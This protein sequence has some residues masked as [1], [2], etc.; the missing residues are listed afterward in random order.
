MSTTC[1]DLMPLKCFEQIRLVA[2]RRGLYR[3]LTWP[4]VCFTPT[5]SQWLHGGE[6]IFVVDSDMQTDVQSLLRF[7]RECIEH[8]MAGMVILVGGESKLSASEELKQLADAQNFP[9][10]EMPWSLKMI[11][12]TQ[13]IA[14]MIVAR[15]EAVS[16]VEHFLEQ[17]YFMPDEPHKMEKLCVLCDIKLRPYAFTSI[18]QVAS[19]IFT[20]GGDMLARL[21]Y[22]L[23]M[24]ERVPNT[25][26]LYMKHLGN[27]LLCG[28]A[29]S[30]EEGQALCMQLIEAFELLEEGIPEQKLRLAISRIHKTDI[31]LPTSYSEA[32]KTLEVMNSDLTSRNILR[33]Q[34]LGVLR[35]FYDA[36]REEL[37]AYCLENLGPL[38]EADRANGSALVSTLKAYLHNNCNLVKAAAELFIHRNTLLYRLNTI[39]QL[40]GK[41]INDPFVKNELFNSLMA[42]DLLGIEQ[43]APH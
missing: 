14:E 10:F 22:A 31:P 7:L 39:R 33:Y 42:L 18:L 25:Q 35:L 26:L 20:Q 12:V 1:I 13:E 6:L 15:R 28:L 4:Y 2:G 34:E 24:R 32:H 17:A 30:Q 37:R 36:P 41:E 21:S 5:I 23:G 38:V 19:G 43:S 9:L 8:N 3:K 16:K 40:L 29:D 27:V 11:D